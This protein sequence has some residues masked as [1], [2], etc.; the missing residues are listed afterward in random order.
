MRASSTLRFT[1]ILL[2]VVGV[3]AAACTDVEKPTE[4]PPMAAASELVANH[5]PK[6]GQLPPTSAL[7]APPLY[8]ALDGASSGAA[9]GA[10]QLGVNASGAIPRHADDFLRSVAVFGYAWVDLDTGRGIVA[11]IHPVIGRDSRQNPAGWHTHPVELIGGTTTSG[12]TS[13]FCLA[14]IGRSQ[15]GLAIH[16]DGLTVTMADRWARLAPGALDVA[17]AFVVQRDAGCSATGLGV[18]VLDTETI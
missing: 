15:A 4:A 9:G 7:L 14:S 18:D 11:V 10:L 3:A 2:A 12:G 17:A 6:Q 13:D 1:A 16:D 8:A 5:M